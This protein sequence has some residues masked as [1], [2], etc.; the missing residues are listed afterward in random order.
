MVTV[1]LIVIYIAFIGLGIPDSL[2]GTAWPAVY[3]E[4]GLPLA[5]GSFVTVILSAGT[6]T[7]SILSA[8]L[9]KR[10]GTGKVTLVSTLLT[11]IAI[12]GI[13]KTGS[14]WFMC[15][16]TLPLG[17]GAGAIDTGLNNYVSMHYSAAQM[18]FLHCFYGIGITLSPYLIAHAMNGEAGWRGGYA[19]A[20]WI[21]VAITL[22]LLISL[23]L[24]KKKSDE[25]PEEDTLVMSFREIASI[26][27]VKCIWGMFFSS[28][29]IE[30]SCGGWACTYLVESKGISAEVG[31]GLILYYYLGIAIGRL[32]AGILAFKFSCQSIVK[33]GLAIMGC[34]LILLV[35]SPSASMAVAALFLI[36]LGNSPMF[37]NFTYLTPIRFGKERSAS[38]MGTQFAVSNIAYMAMPV[39]CSLLG[40]A[41]GMWVFPWFILLAFVALLLSSL[42]FKQRTE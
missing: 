26:P 13:S 27:G 2:F 28:V 31:A 8:R 42:L 9:L 34:G 16:C 25:A 22:I 18:S 3:E 14:F 10:F 20:F 23:P 35:I 19:M 38:I 1:L 15:L 21:Q 37:P 29:T 33:A 24:W 4:F 40:Q 7:S 36:A 5:F 17:L 41:F 30:M 39:V 11:A 6:I 12:L 32:L